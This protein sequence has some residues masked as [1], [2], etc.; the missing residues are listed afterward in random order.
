MTV[1]WSLA[2]GGK[3]KDVQKL[4]TI[5]GAKTMQNAKKAP[6]K[7]PESLDDWKAADIKTWL[8]NNKLAHL[9]S[10]YECDVMPL[11][12]CRRKPK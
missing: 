10:W 7:P 4:A 6:Q 1:T 5:T 11:S 9:Q 12:Q 2:A 3:D 8:K